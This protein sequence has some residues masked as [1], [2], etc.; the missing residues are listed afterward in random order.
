MD[1]CI[2]VECHCLV[3]KASMAKNVHGDMQGNVV[4]FYVVKLG[5]ILPSKEMKFSILKS[6]TFRKI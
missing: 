1:N 6:D 2:N 5:K 4:K 3:G